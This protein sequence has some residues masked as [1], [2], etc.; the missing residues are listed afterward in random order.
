MKNRFQIIL[1]AILV[2][3]ILFAGNY[4]FS[5]VSL[6]ADLT[7]ENEYTLSPATKNILSRANDVITVKLY[8][9]KDVPSYIQNMQDDIINL[10]E[11]FR[12]ASGNKIAIEKVSPDTPALEQEAQNLG[13]PPLQINVIEKDKQEVR[14][15]YLGLVLLYE[16]KK[17][18]LPVVAERSH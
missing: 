8:F 9:T 14:K 18:V 11:E 16:D 4:L 3:A 17:E 7:E 1:L 13:I 6:R 10:I 15:I 12:V 2:A 5:G